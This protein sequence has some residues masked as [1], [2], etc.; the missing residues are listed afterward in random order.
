MER[1]KEP[2]KACMSAS[3]GYNDINTELNSNWDATEWKAMA[4]LL[5]RPRFSKMWILQELAVSSSATT[6]CRQQQ[7]LWKDFWDLIHG[8]KTTGFWHHALVAFGSDNLSTRLLYD[9]VSSITN[10]K[11]MV[12][13]KNSFL[14]QKH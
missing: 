12:E 7:I 14:S 5:Q 8:L 4:A 1:L 6:I 10:I 9:R 11:Q 2:L 13:K 3:N